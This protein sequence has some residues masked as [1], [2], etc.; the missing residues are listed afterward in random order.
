MSTAS[1]VL[2]GVIKGAAAAGAVSKL[3][4]VIV[5]LLDGDVEKAHLLLNE[6]QVRR[7][8]RFAD[9][10]EAAKFPTE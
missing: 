5:D 4:E 8:N 3:V 1:D 7:A 2:D 10:L 9:A 6:E